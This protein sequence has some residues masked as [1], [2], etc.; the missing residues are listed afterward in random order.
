MVEQR[1]KKFRCDEP[2]CFKSYTRPSLLEQHKRSHTNE[3]PYQCRECQ[4]RF[5]RETHL[6]S[7]I[8]THSSTKP[9]SCPQCNKGFITNQQLTRHRRAHH[10]EEFDLDQGVKNKGR[11]SLPEITGPASFDQHQDQQ[12]QYQHTQR[13]ASLDLSYSQMN[14]SNTLAYSNAYPAFSHPM[15]NFE[16]Q[17]ATAS[18][19]SS[20]SSVPQR[21][22][23]SSSSATTTIPT[24]SPQTPLYSSLSIKQEAEHGRLVKCPYDC[25]GVFSDDTSL[26]QHMLQSHIMGDTIPSMGDIPPN[27]QSFSH[28]MANID[29][30]HSQRHGSQL[31]GPSSVDL[32]QQQQQ[33]HNHHHHLSPHTQPHIQSHLQQQHPLPQSHPYQPNVLNKREPYSTEWVDQYRC[34]EPS[35]AGMGSF[36]NISGLLTHYQESHEYIGTNTAATSIT[37][38]TTTTTTTAT[39]AGFNGPT[40]N[41]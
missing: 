40:P 32:Q 7:H 10:P 20:S 28:G 6:K 26:S 39:A 24:A 16:L 2:D 15:N 33:Q 12:L 37:T 4:K 35:C 27:V 5:F 30:T 11:Q 3:R 18:S 17:S 22:H 1:E 9:L 41:I 21:A 23:S 38:T 36:G 34:R 8:W 19:S 29:Y 25:A 14:Y 31:R 13:H